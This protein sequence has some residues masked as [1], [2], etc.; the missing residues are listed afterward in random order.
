MSE[1]SNVSLLYL[2]YSFEINESREVTAV[3]DLG[4]AAEAL[5]GGFR[6]AIC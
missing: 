1:V 2:D 4:L 6:R 5:G 3:S